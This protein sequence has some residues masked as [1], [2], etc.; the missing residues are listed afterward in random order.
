M[1]EE[2]GTRRGAHTS[3]LHPG[4]ETACHPRPHLI[5]RRQSRPRKRVWVRR[6]G[7]RT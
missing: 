2:S 7:D 1:T 3:S 6:G 5:D 4:E